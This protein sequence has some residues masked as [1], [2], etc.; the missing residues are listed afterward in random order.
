MHEAPRHLLI[1]ASSPSCE[2]CVHNAQVSE[3]V[4]S[5]CILLSQALQGLWWVLD[6]QGELLNAKSVYDT[7]M[8][9]S[10]HGKQGD[11]CYHCPRL[12]L[13]KLLQHVSISSNTPEHYPLFCRGVA[14][15]AGHSALTAHT[16]QSCSMEGQLHITSWKEQWGCAALLA[17]MMELAGTFTA[18]M[19]ILL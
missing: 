18:S 9:S 4:S 19:F 11:R 7:T 16:R 10:R 1:I 2:V 17:A 8:Q 5:R 13:P 12:R 15:Q 14:C 6:C 3:A